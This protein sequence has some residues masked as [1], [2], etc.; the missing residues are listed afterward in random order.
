MDSFKILLLDVVYCWSKGATF[1]KVAEMTQHFEGS[2]IRVIRRLEELLRDMANAAHI[3]GNPELEKKFLD[4]ITS[5]KRD[6]VFA[7]SL[8]L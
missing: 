5:I 6:I 3:I 4:G 7:A 1:S 2:I 8:Y